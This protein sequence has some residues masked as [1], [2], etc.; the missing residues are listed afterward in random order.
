[1][2]QMGW[3]GVYA[4]MRRLCLVRD[5]WAPPCPSSSLLWPHSFGEIG[6]SGRTARSKYLTEIHPH[7]AH[8]IDHVVD[9][10]GPLHPVFTQSWG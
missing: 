1:M 4:C 7:T 6:I 3:V 8:I 5:V 10:V 9:T 2:L